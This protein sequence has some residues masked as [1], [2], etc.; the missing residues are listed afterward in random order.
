MP[1]IN[2]IAAFH[3][4][5]KTWRHDIHKHPELAY[6]EHRTAAKVADLLRTF[7]VDEVVEGIGRTGVVGVIRNGDG[8][9]IGLRADMD[10]L[11]IEEH[12]D[13]P[14]TSVH[15]GKMHACGHDGHTAMLL[16]AARYL[17]EVRPFHGTVVLVF[18][19][20]EEGQAGAR[21][22]IDD[23]LFDR[24]PMQAIYGLHNMPGLPA[25]TISISPGP[26]MAAA[27]R[28]RVVLRGQGGHAAAPHQN[29]DPVVAAAALVQALQTIVSRNAP[30]EQ[31][32]VVSV[33]EIHGGD[34]F[35]VIPDSV[36]LA[37]TVRYFEAEVG[38]LARAR[39]KAIIDGIAAAHAVVAD[40]D[41][42]FGYPPTVNW[43]EPVE[44]ARAAAA[45]VL[46]PDKVMDQPPRMFAEDFSFYL[47]EIPGAYGFIGN[48]EL[49]DLGC[50]SLHNADYDFNDDILTAGAS[51][52]V[53]L[54][55]QALGGASD[56]A[57]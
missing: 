52:F 21:A 7:G 48:G 6:E 16:G 54:V 32:L 44:R 35:N 30:P 40:Y 17:A 43:N 49:G 24:F 22:M 25:G 36:R 23:G 37:G 13:R 55:E 1:V 46:G 56:Q 29:R 50:A 3:D 2:R 11:P 10:A 33:T 51:Y 31:T 34:S 45:T 28:F 18:Q 27:D 8:P 53:A 14:Y 57:A 15:P 9:A 12:T 5:M 41:Y 39:M 47:Q 4:A 26:V 38:Q 42:F 19:P 20:A